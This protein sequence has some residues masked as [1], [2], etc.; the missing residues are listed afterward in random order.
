MAQDN[1]AGIAVVEEEEDDDDDDDDD[2]DEIFSPIAL[3]RSF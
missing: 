2:D 3:A 1:A